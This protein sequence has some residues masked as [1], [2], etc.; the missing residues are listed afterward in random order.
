MMCTASSAPMNAPA[1]TST[2]S[3]ASTSS[4]CCPSSSSSSSAG[5]ASAQHESEIQSL[6]SHLSAHF[7]T[8]TRH[9]LALGALH[10][11]RCSYR[12]STEHY[13]RSINFLM[14]REDALNRYSPD[15]LLLAGCTSDNRPSGTRNSGDTS[16]AGC[17]RGDQ[18]V[19]EELAVEIEKM[20]FYTYVLRLNNMKD[21]DMLQR[22]QQQHATASK[23]I[24][25]PIIS[26]TT[27]TCHNMRS[28]KMP[29]P[30]LAFYLDEHNASY[31]LDSHIHPHRLDVSPSSTTSTDNIGTEQT[32]H[33]LKAYVMYN[34]AL[35]HVALGS[36]PESLNLLRM[37]REDGDK[38]PRY[39]RCRPTQLAD[40]MDQYQRFVEDVIVANNGVPPSQLQS[41]STS[42]SDETMDM[43]DMENEEEED[44]GGKSATHGDGDVRLPAASAA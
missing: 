19:Q 31:I 32:I 15:F 11:Q 42:S 39:G 34:L 37:V 43:M 23:L 13:Q 28:R 14:R 27:P 18:I 25:L 38:D 17:G 9:H 35:C 10:Y 20:E 24:E 33:L 5:A 30:R 44:Q 29:P 8:A 6:L 4:M 36:Y 3:A 21:M 40:I 16:T 26:T 2:S 12:S 22:E 41:C 7:I 1:S